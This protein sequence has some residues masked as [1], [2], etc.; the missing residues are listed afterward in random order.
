MNPLSLF[1]LAHAVVGANVTVELLLGPASSSDGPTVE[2]AVDGA[3]SIAVDLE[4]PAHPS[5]TGLPSS[6]QNSTFNA[7]TQSPSPN[8]GFLSEGVLSAKP[9][10]G[11]LWGWVAM[12]VVLTGGGY[13]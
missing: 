7:A 9:T 3:G 6:T 2:I 12:C 4:A 8:L 5:P 1:L 10:V 13:Y 11:P